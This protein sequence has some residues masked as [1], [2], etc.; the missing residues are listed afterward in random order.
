MKS[1]FLVFGVTL[2]LL[3][4]SPMVSVLSSHETE[5]VIKFGIFPYKS[6][7]TIV[8]LFGPIVKRLEA[9]LGM[10]V[11]L[12]TAPD[13]KTYVA[14][15]SKG[16]YDLA[17]PCVHCFFLMQE[18]G[19]TVIARG[20]PDFYG[21]LVVHRDSGIN[22]IEQLRGMKI[23]AIGRHSYAGYLFMV[24]RL[25]ERGIDPAGEV[26]FSFLGKLDSVLFAVLNGTYDAGIVRRDALA[27]PQFADLRSDLVF[28]A[29]SLPIPQFP[30]V[31]K[32][33]MPADHVATIRRVLTAFSMADPDD[34]QILE[35]LRI[36]AISPA[37]DAHYEEFRG[38][39]QQTLELAP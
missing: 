4:C 24:A 20:Q 28:I 8:R 6:P 18:A 23:A 7:R 14:R 2:W 13:F 9:E 26:E 25:Y 21:G 30:F 36:T 31:V 33:D 34:R 19:Y 10:Q 37:V 12:V 22:D 3:I 38:R 29:T 32:K 39:L 5:H 1:Y 15:G 27:D 35:S 16:D 11:Q 17:F